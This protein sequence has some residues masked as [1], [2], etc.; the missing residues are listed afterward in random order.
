[1]LPSFTGKLILVLSYIFSY[2]YESCISYIPPGEPPGSCE[3]C[4]KITITLY[5]KFN[6]DRKSISWV[7]HNLVKVLNV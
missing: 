7:A 2:I 5:S 4:H 1:M 3:H 6:G